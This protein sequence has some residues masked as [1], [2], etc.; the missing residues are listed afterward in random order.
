VTVVL[1]THVLHWLSSEPQR[2]SDSAKRAIQESDELAVAD[3]TWFELAWLARRGRITISR[4]MERWLMD[5]AQQVRSIP[6]TPRIAAVAALL[7]DPFP[8]DPADRVIYATAME[9]GWSLVT[10]DERLRS[11]ATDPV[12]TIW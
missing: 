1:D 12:I 10:R 11:Y 4:P 2:I 3:V 6:V 8:G 7:A 9:N 5:L